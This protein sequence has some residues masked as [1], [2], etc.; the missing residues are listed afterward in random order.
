M[1][2]TT[3]LGDLR[4]G[5][6]V[7]WTVD[8]DADRDR[9]VVDY[10]HGAVQARHK[11]VF[12][13][14][15]TAPEQSLRVLAAAGVDVAALTGRG[16]LE[17]RSAQRTYLRWGRF[18]RADMIETC[19]QAGVEAREARFPGLRLVGDMGWAAGPVPGTEELHRYEAEINRLYATG[20]MIGLCLYDRRLFD[21]D[22]LARL[23]AVH[24]GAGEPADDGPWR[25]LLRI[26]T[27]DDEPGL[28]LDG[29]SD[30]SNRDALVAV[31][32]GLQPSPSDPPRLHVGALRFAD[33]ATTRH[34]L[35]T[36]DRLGGLRVVGASLT[37]TRLLA[38]CGSASVPGLRLEPAAGTTATTPTTS[39]PA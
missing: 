16:Q 18:D 26:Q 29:E 15:A 31:L 5:D 7:C 6:H 11:V 21:H 14:H 33:V 1:P 39:A 37:L 8:T 22:R 4:P 38:F 32:D 23:H 10:V 9:A 27:L 19:R 36:A 2:R 30:L 34:I 28:R 24:P 13:T 12:I 25:P 3:L 35:Q 20:Y 17:V